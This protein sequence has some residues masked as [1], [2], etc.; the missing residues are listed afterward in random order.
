MFVGYIFY[1]NLTNIKGGRG[2]REM[3][4]HNDA[5]RVNKLNIIIQ[6]KKCSIFNNFIH[7]WKFIPKN[8][9]MNPNADQLA[10]DGAHSK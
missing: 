10:K 9:D 7:I 3:S 2:S 8:V 4:L 1:I 5:S 6:N